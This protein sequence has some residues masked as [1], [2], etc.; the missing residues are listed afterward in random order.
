MMA[1]RILWA[2]WAVA[3]VA[4]VGQT[5]AQAATLCTGTIASFTGAGNACTSVNFTVLFTATTVSGAPVPV[6]DSHFDV[7]ITSGGTGDLEVNI[8]PDATANDTISGPGGFNSEQYNFHY[9]V[10][11]SP[12]FAM[13][14]ATITIANATIGTGFGAVT[15]F[16][17]LDGTYQIN[18]GSLAGTGPLGPSTLTNSMMLPYLSTPVTVED[19]NTIIGVGQIGNGPGAPGSVEND[20]S[21][22]A[23]PEPFTFA[24]CG[25][26]L[27][28]VGLLR[29]KNTK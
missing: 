26:G 23:A 13:T 1:K 14:G 4:I 15:G 7:T 29:R 25:L 2:L 18:A 24:L 8:A 10:S 3:V 9:T 20:L 5:T 27:L 19:D 21:F 16:K 28:G 6:S 17:E 12:S 11:F 22:S